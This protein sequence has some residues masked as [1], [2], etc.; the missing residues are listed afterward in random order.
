MRHRKKGRYFNRNSAHRLAM[1][2]NMANALINYEIIKTTLSKAKE[3][4][5]IIEPIITMA[6]KNNIASRRLVRSKLKNKKNINKLFNIIIPKFQNI[7]GGYTRIIKCG[8]RN[9]DRAP[10][11]YIELIER[12]KIIKKTKKIM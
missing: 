3:L 5:I 7:L 1:L 4:R 6:K 12:K 11:A 10:M 8:F 9:G 2:Y